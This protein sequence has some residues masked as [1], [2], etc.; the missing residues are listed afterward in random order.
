MLYN[1][2]DNLNKVFLGG[3]C[4]ESTWRDDLIKLLKIN[5]FNPIVK[6]RNEEVMNEELKQRKEC[7]FLLYTITPEMKEVYSI[8]GV[9]DDSNKNPKKTIL[10]ILKEPG[11]FDVS[12]L[13]SL[14]AV[15]KMVVR[16]GGRYVSSLEETA[17]ILNEGTTAT[18]QLKDITNYDPSKLNND[19]LQDDWRWIVTYWS[20]VRAG[21]NF[22]YTKE[23]IEKY[24]LDIYKEITKRIKEGSIVHEFKTDLSKLLVEEITSKKTTSIG[25]T[26]N[27]SYDIPIGSLIEIDITDLS[28]Y[29]D[30]D[31]TVSF[32]MYSPTV[33]GLGKDR[34]SSIKE[35]EDL[36]MKTTGRVE[37]LSETEQ[38]KEPP[39]VVDMH[40]AAV[41]HADFRFWVNDQIEGFTCAIV[42]DNLK[43]PWEIKDKTV[44]FNGEVYYKI[45]DGEPTTP[46]KEMNNKVIKYYK[47]VMKVPSNWKISMNTGVPK[48]RAGTE[49]NKVEKI[50]ATKKLPCT[51]KRCIGWFKYEGL[52]LP[53]KID[54]NA[55]GSTTNYPGVF[56]ILSSGVFSKGVEKPYFSEYFIDGTWGKKRILFTKIVGRKSKIDTE[57]GPQW[58]YSVPDDQKP[59]I[60]SARAIKKN[61][62]PDG[63]SA[64]P[65][66]MTSKV[67]KELIYWD[68]KVDRK[69]RF[70]RLK[71]VQ[72]LL[73]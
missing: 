62:L 66:S 38:T 69:E 2:F 26:Y 7:S 9:V 3:T 35:L 42:E 55:V 72:K 50:W 41:M 67:P 59:Y 6:N 68:S 39:Y 1:A 52:Q 34:T 57:V 47:D 20:S 17:K 31:G 4:A 53:E 14:D 64:L 60:L 13:K 49:G 23:E 18:E 30:K 73:K 63:W 45:I 33:I 46:T 11:S 21:K 43:D 28:K 70:N 40:H 61:Y 22:K 12:Q 19:V 29:V 10:C 5:Y 44:L 32:K 27:S 15:G 65:K 54:S 8:A 25:N 71:Q 36:V 48:K 58:F 56:I 37:S 51:D 24:A 16:N